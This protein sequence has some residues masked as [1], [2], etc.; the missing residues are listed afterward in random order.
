MDWIKKH[1]EE[2]IARQAVEAARREE[3][4]VRRKRQEARFT[5]IKQQ[6]CPIIVAV[7]EK[8]EH[9]A[10]IKLIVEIGATSVVVRVV[11]YSQRASQPV[12]GDCF[13]I[14]DPSEDGQTVGIVVI[15]GGETGEGEVLF[16]G[17]N[18][19][20]P[21]IRHD[22]HLLL[23]WL[24]QMANEE[25]RKSLAAPAITGLVEWER[26]QE[27]ARAKDQAVG[28]ARFA[29]YTSIASLLLLFL[30]APIAVILGIYAHRRLGRL[31]SSSDEKRM[32]EWAIALG[33]GQCCLGL[34]VAY[35]ISL[36][37]DL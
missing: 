22:I 20:G 6:L 35:F 16:A 33:V 13:T 10:G 18:S 29:L 26:S 17:R 2:Y 1:E 4:D 30:L 15:R 21:L 8:L 12:A 36:G 5:T 14:A 11:R 9:R 19:I 25:K 27:Q 34:M 7:Q 24:A 31:G 32:A 37:L 3:C 28:V 23:D